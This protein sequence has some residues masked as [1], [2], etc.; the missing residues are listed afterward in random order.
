MLI[1]PNETTLKGRVTRVEMA[2]DGFGG[3]VSIEVTEVPAGDDS[4]DFVGT[5]PGATLRLFA[6]EPHKV[7]QGELYSVTASMVGDARGQRLVMRSAR[8]LAGR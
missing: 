7:K 5:S 6:A 8:K 1:K 3:D 2:A 4:P